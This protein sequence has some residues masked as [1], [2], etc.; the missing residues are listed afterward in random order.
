[1]AQGLCGHVQKQMKMSILCHCLLEKEAWK[2][3]ILED[4]GLLIWVEGGWGVGCTMIYEVVNQSVK[5]RGN[6]NYNDKKK[7]IIFTWQKNSPRSKGK[8]NKSPHKVPLTIFPSRL[9]NKLYQIWF[10]P[11]AMSKMIHKCSPQSL[12]LGWPLLVHAD[13]GGEGQDQV[14]AGQRDVRAPCAPIGCSV[15][16]CGQG[17]KR[18]CD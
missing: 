3:L 10:Q 4:W 16:G 5:K 13:E 12:C 9:F 18:S 1:M 11:S 2:W 17:N 6:N 8:K 14:P 7:T 15:G